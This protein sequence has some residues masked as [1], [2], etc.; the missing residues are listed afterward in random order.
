MDR[1]EYRKEIDRVVREGRFQDNWDS[2]SGYELPDW[3]RS[4]KFGIFIHWGVYSVPAYGSEWYSRNMYIQGS[5]E[6]EHHIKTY[7]CHENFGYKDFIPMFQAEQFNANEWAEL[8]SSSG[9]R[10]VVPV[11]EHHDGF[12]M[13][14]SNLS[15]FN[16]FEMGPK[17]DVLGELK[18]ALHEKNII[19][20]ASSHRVE[21]WFFM[22]HGKEF[23][24]DIKE[25]LK[26]GDFYWPAMPEPNHQ[27]LFSLA[28][29]EEFLEDWLL[30]TCEIV[31]RYHPNIVYFDW[32][33]Q[34]SSVKPYLKI[35]AAYYYNRAIEWGQKVV[36]NYKHD[37]FM[38]GCAVVD[39][40]RG[41]F[42]E[43]K[44]YFW[45]TDTAVALNS[46]GYTENNEYK[47]AKEII[48]DLVDIVSKNGCL[49]LNIGP[50]S[51]GTI[52]EKDKEI[53][54]EIGE[55]LAVNG[56]GIYDSKVWRVAGE[57]PT[58]I[59]E[60]QFTDTK[61]KVFTKEDIRFTV[62]GSYVYA[63]VLRYPED[64]LVSIKALGEKNAARLPHFH[65]IIKDV[66]V[67]GFNEK[68]EWTREEEALR[69]KT[70]SIYSD[71][72]V[73]FKILIE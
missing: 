44:P 2:L 63:Y 8:F 62:K 55:W 1:I 41:Q 71:K 26:C 66:T 16:S 33:I 6:Y 11:A 27:D 54:L 13:Y 53:L 25:P 65:G 31:D 67:L 69:I 52:P 60:G 42:A 61:A 70:Q 28:P 64:G 34:H 51:N 38:F 58:Q 37:A 23:N 19:L 21:H 73:A 46:W 56:E 45:Q 22:G 50:K 9:A 43:Q 36:I 29:S 30:R 39:I 4:A 59:E 47:K 40:E 72:P 17:R 24:S 48:C 3:Y 35:F 68:P 15:H 18:E 32:W 12:Q 7:G 49:L 14:K 57:G 10:Y 5:K 20:G